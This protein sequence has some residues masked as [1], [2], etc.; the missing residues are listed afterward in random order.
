MSID[1][2]E[3]ESRQGKLFRD[4][5]NV[6]AG[7]SANV[8]FTI[9][10]EKPAMAAEQSPVQLP[11][12]VDAERKAAQ[13]IRDLGGWY[14]LDDEQRV[15]EVNMVYHKTQEGV[16]Y[17]NKDFGTDEALRQVP[18]F[19]R[20]QRLF[21]QKQQANDEALGSLT[22]LKDLRILMLWDADLVSDAGIQRLAVLDKLENLHVGGGR[23]SDAS[24]KVLA[25]L[26]RLTRLSLQGHSLSDDGLKN[27]TAMRQLRALYVGMS[28]REITDAGLRHLAGLKDLEELDLQSARLT[29]EGVAVLK[30]F[31]SLRVLNLN[32]RDAYADPS[33]T[34][35][36]V[37]T[38]ASLERLERLMIQNT[39][40]TP[41]GLKRLI[42][43][44]RLKQ[45]IVSSSAIPPESQ[46]ALQ[47]AKPSLQLLF[48]RPKAAE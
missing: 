14:Q 29:D 48:S 37:A 46:E 13:A 18:A 1:V 36:S 28:Q 38:L 44:P 2:G 39:R 20:L 47:K 25:R 34:D 9:L 21:L 22:G 3:R 8:T 24:L 40:I 43:L 7:K 19:P 16:R 31:R 45:L 41:D 6:E 15:A 10:P 27:L 30:N 26:P 35:A 17:D 32:G 4:G 11:L 33:I 42:E 5:L 23:L 12:P